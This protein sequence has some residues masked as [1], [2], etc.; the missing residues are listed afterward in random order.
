MPVI[1]DVTMRMAEVAGIKTAIHGLI[2][3]RSDE[4]AYIVRRFDRKKIGKKNIKIA[5]EDF[6]Q[7]SQ[8]LTEQKY[9]TSME[10]AGKIILEFSSNP[11]LDIVIFFELAIFSFL[12]GNADMHLKNFSLIVNENREVIFSPAYDLLSTYLLPI[13]DSEEMA[14]TVNG[15]KAKLKRKDF[16]MLGAT[17]RIPEKV[18]KTRF[19]KLGK[20]IPQMKNI[21]NRSFL[22][23]ELKDRYHELIEVRAAVFGL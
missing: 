7:L 2:R 9:K 22:S 13:N 4:L 19:E 12:T 1:E 8:L 23:E 11:G 15:K 3:L 5:V 18:I 10:K 16:E 17:L 6:C 14:L 20:A 21:I